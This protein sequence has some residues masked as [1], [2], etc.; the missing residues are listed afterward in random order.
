M[1]ALLVLLV[2]LVGC[3]DVPT[4]PTVCEGLRVHAQVAYA[5]MARGE[6]TC[7]PTGEAGG[8]WTCVCVE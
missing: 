3:S 1:R 4:R 5:L 2:T 7:E 6:A 8:A